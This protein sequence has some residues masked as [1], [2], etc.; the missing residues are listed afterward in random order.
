LGPILGQSLIVALALLAATPAFAKKKATTEVAPPP[1]AEPE[2][3]KLVAPTPDTFGRVH[4]GPTS[5]AGLGRLSIK[6]PAGDK[7]QVFLE[8]RYFGEAPLT[9]YSVPKGDYIVEGTYPDGK[10]MSRPV[11]VGENEEALADLSGGHVPAGA[12]ASGPMFSTND[13]PPGRVTAAKV[14]AIAGGAGLVVGA[15]FGYL[16]LRKEN[17]YRDAP[18]DQA[19]LDNIRNTGKTYALIADVGF[20]VGIASLVGAAVCAY[21]MVVKSEKKE[22]T[23]AFVVVPGPSS[24]TSSF[25]M[26]F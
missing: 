15:V 3:P 2:K 13:V 8:G 25:A 21:P 6:A 1:P 16:M 22:T 5:A 10:T 19:Q 17:E 23:T 14:F 24:V 11:S 20:A 18:N 26:Q 4:F 9:I 7:V 12:A